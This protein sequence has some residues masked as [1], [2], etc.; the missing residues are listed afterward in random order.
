VAGFLGVISG[1]VQLQIGQAVAAYATL[2]AQ[3]ARTVYALRGTGDAF[4]AAGQRMTVAGA[5]LIYIFGKAVMAAAEFERK[6]DFFGAV[7]DTNTRK[8]AKLSEFTLQLAQDTIYSAEQIADGFIE[9][10]KAGVSAEQIMRGIGK[11]MA[12]L[13]AAGDI[14]LAQSGQIITSTIQQFDLA[15]KDAVSVVDLLA[16][17]ANASIAD[18][19]DIGV[20]LKYVG[21]VANAVGLTF[22][23]TTTAISLLAKAGIRGSTAGTSLRQ[24]LVSLGGATGPAREVLRELGIITGENNNKFF[25]AEGRAKSLAEV[26]Q[27]LQTHTADLTQKE[28]LMALRTIFNNR[29]LSAASI[30]TR[31]GAKGFRE[32]NK[33]MAKTTAAD[34]AA[35][36]MDN[37]SGDIEIL[38]GNIQ[39]M[40]IKAGTPFQETLRGWVRAITRAVQAFGN[41]DPQIQ[42]MITQTVALTGVALVLMGTFTV[43]VGTVFRFLAAMK[44]LGAGIAFLARILG[45]ASG[46]VG[47]FG[48]LVGPA[49]AGGLGLTVGAALAVIAVIAALVVGFVVAYKKIEP[50]R[51]LVNS[52]AD[53]IWKSI[54]AVGKFLKL[55]FTDP[56]AVWE[57]M[58]TAAIEFADW[59]GNQFSKIGPLIGKALNSAAGFA[60]RFIGR[61]VGFFRSLPGRVLGILGD[62]VGAILSLF[63]FQNLGR[64]IGLA[65]GLIPQLFILLRLA[66]I[67]L[68]FNT[69]TGLVK[70]FAGLG[71]KIGYAIGFMI[72]LVV[73][74]LFQL[75]TKTLQLG[76][77]ITNGLIRFF[78]SLPG[79]IWRLMVATGAR[80]LAQLPG[81]IAAWLARTVTRLIGAVPEFLAGARDIGRNVINGFLEYVGRLPSIVWEAI[82]NTIQAFKDMVGSAFNAA[83]DFAKGLWD[84]FKD[85]LFGS[86]RTKIEY[87]IEAM[88]ETVGRETKRLKGQVLQVQKYGQ[89]MGKTDFGKGL[90]DSVVTLSA[91]RKMVD[92]FGG[93]QATAIGRKTSRTEQ[94]LREQ[95]TKLRLTE[96]KLRIDED[97]TGFFRG[98]AEEVVDSDSH[99]DEG[100]RRAGFKR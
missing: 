63:T 75:W 16:G 45:I 79:R 85:G 29:A 61:V 53:A 43:I 35:E 82:G 23:D 19:T 17:A 44:K 67:T 90:T 59:V 8:M 5:G 40:L 87:A 26:F 41:L 84:G 62:M 97:G 60:S 24:M 88:T 100:L 42:K 95:R 6:M 70:L 56:G 32:M 81:K 78:V 48:I 13:G 83:K 55:L 96:G 15:A 98:L 18:I 28:R 66:L 14:P 71:P 51:N 50:F 25:D 9:L 80:L 54:Q 11:A 94:A 64:V 65:L 57:K 52:V 36:R 33:E 76:R 93:T 4:V 39:T 20:S 91:T 86:P 58:K 89:M 34:V 10:G 72:G 3:N 49:I 68:V 37:L 77:A 92:D 47:L 46:A 99:Y 27:I 74:L 21:G 7:T 22:E 73:R 2:R 12:N 38:Q 1:R 30:L 69:I 31:E